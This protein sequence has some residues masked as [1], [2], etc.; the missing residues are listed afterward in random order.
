MQTNRRRAM[1]CE[2]TTSLFSCLSFQI[3]LEKKSNGMDP[4]HP[5]ETR[6][7]EVQ[8]QALDGVVLTHRCLSQVVVP[9]V[10]TGFESKLSM[11]RSFS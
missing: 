1:H 9:T 6:W 10:V 11:L 5:F 4:N 3:I 7:W 8:P 2:D